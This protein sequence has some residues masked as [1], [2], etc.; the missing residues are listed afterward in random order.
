MEEIGVRQS[1]QNIAFHVIFLVLWSGI[2]LLLVDAYRTGKVKRMRHVYQGHSKEYWAN[3]YWDK[4]QNPVSFGV[5]VA[6][7]IVIL[8]LFT[9]I[10]F[11]P[12]L[13]A[14]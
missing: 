9:L 14:L 8:I 12:L 2:A 13:Q 7:Y 11:L 5:S 6:G 3:P 1:I 4:K 10:I